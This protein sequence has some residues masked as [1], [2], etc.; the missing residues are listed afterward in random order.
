MKSATTNEEKKLCKKF[1]DDRTV[2]P[3]TGRKI[4]EGGPTYKDLMNKCAKYFVEPKDAPQHPLPM[5]PFM[6]FDIEKEYKVYTVKDF[7]KQMVPMIN[8]ISDRLKETNKL[9]CYSKFEFDDFSKQLK[10]MLRWINNSFI[11][12]DKKYIKY[13]NACK[14]L[15]KDIETIKTRNYEYDDTPK[16]AIVENIEVKPDRY[17]LRH[18]VNF[19]FSL[20]QTAFETMKIAL[21][22]N[23]ITFIVGISDIINDKKYLDYLIKHKIFSY[24]DIYKNTFPSENVFEELKEIY[25]KYMVL[26]NQVKK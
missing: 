17:F 8:F 2:N 4:K 5:G 3:A 11:S 21:H 10:S 7:E 22:N 25:K 26:Y 12:T 9:E 20:Y 24:D 13:T 6:I 23:E 18:K 14:K 1:K 16:Y 15:Q 19:L